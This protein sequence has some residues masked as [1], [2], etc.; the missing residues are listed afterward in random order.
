MTLNQLNVDNKIGGKRRR[1][2]TGKRSRGR[3]GGSFLGD[4]SVPAGLLLLNQYL[5]HRKSKKSKQ[6][7]KRKG[8]KTRR[9]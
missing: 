4:V 8:K 5:K 6:S 7:K 9:R 3:K 1:R 2:K